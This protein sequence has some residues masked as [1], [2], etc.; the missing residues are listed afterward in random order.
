MKIKKFMVETNKELKKHSYNAK[1]IMEEVNPRVESSIE[2][3]W[4]H[5]DYV[6]EAFYWGYIEDE[7]YVKVDKANSVDKA[8]REIK[9]GDL[10]LAKLHNITGIY[11]LCKKGFT[12]FEVK[13]YA[14]DE[15]GDAFLIDTELNRVNLRLAYT[16]DRVYFYKK[17]NTIKNEIIPKDNGFKGWEI[18]E[19]DNHVINEEMVLNDDLIHWN[20][21][22]YKRIIEDEI[23]TEEDLKKVSFV[24]NT[25]FVIIENGRIYRFKKFEPFS[26]RN[27]DYYMVLERIVDN[28]KTNTTVSGVLDFVKDGIIS[29]YVNEDCLE[30]E[31]IPVATQ[32]TGKE[33]MDENKNLF[34]ENELV[35]VKELNVEPEK[36][37]MVSKGITYK[38]VP[39]DLI[40]DSN[41][42]RL[43][44]PGGISITTNNISNKIWYLKEI[45]GKDKDFFTFERSDNY[46]V[47][48]KVPRSSVI[49]SFQMKMNTLWIMDKYYN[50]FVMPSNSGYEDMFESVNSNEVNTIKIKGKKYYR[51]NESYILNIPNLLKFLVP[52]KS[53]IV[54]D[55]NNLD[56]LYF[57]NIDE[58]N[59]EEAVFVLNDIDD[60]DNLR[61][62]KIKK[63]FDMLIFYSGISL[64]VEEDVAVN[65]GIIDISPDEDGSGFLDFDDKENKDELENLNEGTII[66][67]KKTMVI[68]DKK[69]NYYKVLSEGK[70]YKYDINNLKYDYTHGK[71]KIKVRK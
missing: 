54:I 22:V 1:T 58:T 40:D 19:S 63:L 4:K 56:V 13:T 42:E 51:V 50:K 68:I 12:E 23:K 70:E 45:T 41:I 53:I 57:Y 17:S 5:K 8:F 7:I 36:D 64:Y 26:G 61:V 32:L 2:Y 24:D 14:F 69:N 44:V 3:A 59:D 65:N 37:T 16:L 18:D 66:T 60:R 67:G 10:I 31:D 46:N 20:D 9:E 25:F 35:D 62:L 48:D 47:V 43:F 33:F 29:I 38:K 21:K 27:D 34:E 30:G 11:K 71:I 39:Y 6:P 55:N 28:S 15:D 52:H 49:G